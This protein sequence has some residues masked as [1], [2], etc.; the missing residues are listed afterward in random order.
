MR[1]PALVANAVVC[2]LLLSGCAAKVGAPGGGVYPVDEDGEECSDGTARG[3]VYV[4][5]D[6]ADGR[7]SATPANCLVNKGGK[8]TLRTKEN[9]T[10]KFEI[11]FAGQSAAG[12]NEPRKLGS[13]PG[14]NREK[15]RFDA[16][17]AEGTY[18]Y[19]LYVN[20]VPLDPAIIIR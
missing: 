3:K 9:V 4:T 11:E 14:T 18:K 16:N 20:G 8:V 13:Q 6:F 19:T 7:P 15:I 5:I 12:P 17:N 1:A 10:T 2:V